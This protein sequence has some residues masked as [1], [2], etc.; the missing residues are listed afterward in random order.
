NRFYR[1][2]SE[3]IVASWMTRQD[4]ELAIAD[5]LAYVAAVIDTVIRELPAP[6][7][8]VISGFSQGV[9]MAFR[10]ACASTRAIA[11]VIAAGG[12]VPPELT[13]D[14][15]RKIPAVLLTRGEHDQWY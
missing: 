15:L 6:S 2:R 13:A 4:R 12:D 7:P 10:S 3:E 5:N 14:Q 1:S 8:L 11:G 9:A